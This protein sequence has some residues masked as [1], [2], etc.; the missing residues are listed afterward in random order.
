MFHRSEP[1]VIG[2]QSLPQNSSSPAGG[3]DVGEG[4]RTTFDIDKTAGGRAPGTTDE[5]QDDQRQ[6]EPPPPFPN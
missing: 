1:A 4:T 3:D 2:A 6:R 5:R